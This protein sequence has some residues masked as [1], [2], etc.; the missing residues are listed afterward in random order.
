MDPLTTAGVIAVV[1]VSITTHEAAHGFV[2]DRL[3]AI[4]RNQ[5]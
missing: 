5:R 1:V 2:A 3:G 4:T